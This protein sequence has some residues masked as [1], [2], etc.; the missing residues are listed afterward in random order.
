[1]KRRRQTFLELGKRARFGRPAQKAPAPVVPPPRPED[2]PPF[3]LGTWH[4]EPLRTRMTRGDR[5]AEL[6]QQ[7][8]AAVLILAAAPA[9]GVNREQ[10][11]LSIFGPSH[12]ETHPEKIRRVLSTLR[13]LFSEDGS[14]RIVNMPGDAYALEFGA[15]REERPVVADDDA[16]LQEKAPAVDAWLGRRRPRTLAIA[17]AAVAVGIMSVTLLFMV[18]RKEGA[19]YGTV[20]KVT[21][22]ASGPGLQLSPSFSQDGS[23]IVYTW[24]KPD[25]S[26]KLYVLAR[27]GGTPRQLTEGEGR[28]RFP[29]WAPRGG[30]IAFQRVVP[31]SCSVMVVAADGGETRRIAACDF[32]SGGPMTWLPDGN[33]LTFTNRSAWNYASQIV[34]VSVEDGT[35]IGVTNPTIGM[36]GD[37]HPALASS[38]RRLAFV[39]TRAPGVEDAYLLEI[40]GKPE[41]LTRDALPLAGL[42]WE[43][44]GLSLLVASPRMGYDALWRVRL[45][46]AA[47]AP[48]LRLGDPV[49][50][51]ALTDDGAALAYEHWH[52]TTRFVVHGA[53]AEEVAGKPWREGGGLD[54][55]AQRSADGQHA[56]FVSNLA[57]HEQLWL[58]AGDGSDPAPLT[59]SKFEY[60]ETPRF[61]PDGTQVV[62]GAVRDGH[63]GAWVVDIATGGEVL[64]SGDGDARAPSFSRSG[65]W[66]YFSSNRSGNRWQLY[67][68]PW[69]KDGAAEQLTLEGGF[70]ARESTDGEMLYFVRPD[71]RGLWRR[72]PAPGGDDSLVTAELAPIDWRNWDVAPD[73][74][75][76]VMRPA[77]DP[78]LAR[79]VFATGRVIPGPIIPDLLQDSGLML[80]SDG[81]G[82][83]VA[84]TADTQVDIEIATLK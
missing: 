59:R 21:V 27:S 2:V 73:A 3:D 20:D 28:D 14:V 7:V 38:G 53:I 51:P 71:R 62:F 55:G 32:G 44:R 63:F 43:P 36:P 39:R 84:E 42:A 46:G 41:H 67:R 57:G 19:F 25:G 1:M 30:L 40:G 82:A 56:V 11:I 4:V 72:S 17:A 75:W 77:G 66:L 12:A 70:A 54:R 35:L 37:S 47:P 49:R 52:V 16:P 81:R 79:F 65:K 34:S 29:A 68:R 9:E 58:A 60:I 45:D 33:V 13:R 23:R 50:H 24:R 78:T 18:G 5:V 76:F 26:E 61:S 69:P 8:L 48:I 10:L 15:P 22:L 31:G 6:D 83:I 80:T 64:A 74:V